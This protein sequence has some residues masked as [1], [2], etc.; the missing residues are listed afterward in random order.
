MMDTSEVAPKPE[1][2][3]NYFKKLWAYRKYINMEPFM[4]FYIMPS[5]FNAVAIQNFPLEKACRV[6]YNYSEIVCKA[7]LD[8]EEFGIEDCDGFNFE[9]VTEIGSGLLWNVTNLSP[10]FNYTVCK[11]ERD[12]QKLSAEVSGIRAPIAAI[13]PLIVILFAGG[14]SDRY[15]KR[16]PCIMF[17]LIGEGLQFLGL[18][19]SAIFFDVFPMEFGAYIESIVP[20]MFGGFNFVLMAVYGYITNATPEPDRIFRFGIFSMFINCIPFVGI[21]FSGILYQKLGYVYSF[22]MSW[23]FQLIAFFYV[24]FFIKEIPQISDKDKEGELG[25]T[26]TAFEVTDVTEVNGNREA[27]SALDAAISTGQEP[28][29]KKSCLAEFFDPTLAIECIKMPFEKRANYGQALF[30]LMMIAYFLTAGPAAGENDYWYRYMLIKLN[31]NGNQFSA[32]S[33]FSSASTIL[34]TFIGT[35]ILSKLLKISD[36]A[37]GVLSAL[38]IVISRPMFAFAKDSVM[39]YSAGLVE[40]F[41]S[42]RVIAI[43]AIG[44]SIVEGDELG[45]MYAIFGVTDPIST[46]II[47][48]LYSY[49]YKTTVDTFPGAIFLFSEVFYVPNVIVFIIC[50]V[51]MKR[52]ERKGEK[53]DLGSTKPA[54]KSKLDENLESQTEITSL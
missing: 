9:N 36:P 3:E 39:Y 48:P 34:G 17:P 49:V 24:L 8:K 41:V 44:S 53:I 37:I 26:N 45:R 6:N 40:M 30:V 1:A 42:L 10:N 43:K 25:T 27:I 33:T 4:F 11:A 31:W 15:N 28:P 19:I 7:I 52:R 16:K 20:S 35:A 14:W 38:C 23:I 22:A 50:Y 29:P 32:Y 5:V 2:K 13:F 51:L 21:P 47:P 12:A 54:D 46:F 18:F